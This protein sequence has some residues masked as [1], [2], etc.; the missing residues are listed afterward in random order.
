MEQG[1]RIPYVE[2]YILEIH[3][4]HNVVAIYGHYKVSKEENKHNQI[5]VEEIEV[6]LS[7]E[8]M[9]HVQHDKGHDQVDPE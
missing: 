7:W 4:Q 5:L 9:R 6:M 8:R 3:I 2:N 1:I